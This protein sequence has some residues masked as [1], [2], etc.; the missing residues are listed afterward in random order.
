MFGRFILGLSKFRREHKLDRVVLTTHGGNLEQHIPLIDC[1][2]DHVNISRHAISDEDNYRIF[3]TSS[4]PSTYDLIKLI[5]KIH[6][7]TSCDV[8]LNCVVKP[9]V[10]FKFCYDFVEYAKSIGADAVSFRKE[11][12]DVTP[13]AT[14]LLFE[15]VFGNIVGRSNCPVCRGM[16]QR[17]QGF[18]VRWKG[19]VAEPSIQTNGVY[20]VVIHPDGKPYADWSM[21]KPIHQTEKVKKTAGKPKVVEESHHSCGGMSCGSSSC[22]YSSCG[23]HG[24]GSS[25]RC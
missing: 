22:G 17:V 7:E 25:S 10:D 12:S 16:G 4:V 20:E 21:T 13:T 24:C 6:N 2:V 3:H 11:A 1:A 23:S 18:P 15:K 9:D 19:S 14:E 5:K 8:T